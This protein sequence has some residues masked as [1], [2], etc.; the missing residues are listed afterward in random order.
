MN[1]F[2]MMKF[3]EKYGVEEFEKYQK[4]HEDIYSLEELSTLLNRFLENKALT[5]NSMCQSKISRLSGLSKSYINEL[6]SFNPKKQKKPSRDVLLRIG[7][8]MS[9]DKSEIDMLLKTSGFKELYPRNPRDIAIM[10]ALERGYTLEEA[11]EYL[12]EKELAPLEK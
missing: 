11:S 10:V 1:T 7:F 6:F 8:A 12:E 4:E 9:L 2:D 3:I 5:D